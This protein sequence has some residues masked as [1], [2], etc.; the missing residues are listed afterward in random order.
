MHV[1][2][3]IAIQDPKISPKFPQ[4][5]PKISQRFPQVVTKKSPLSIIL[6]ILKA[7]AFQKY[8]K[9]KV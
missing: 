3:R 7:L 1:A 2:P 6:D 4:D 8:S 5:F 9:L